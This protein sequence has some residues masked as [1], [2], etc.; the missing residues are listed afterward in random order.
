MDKTG[1]SNSNDFDQ[2]KMLMDYLSAMQ[3]SSNGGGGGGGGMQGNNGGMPGNNASIQDMMMA[4]QYL[5][6]M[7]NMGMGSGMPDFSNAGAGGSGPGGFGGN[8][9]M[10]PAAWGMNQYPPYLQFLNSHFHK[11]FMKQ[12]NNVH[13]SQMEAVKKETVVTR[14]STSG[15]SN[16]EAKRYECEY[17]HKTF[18]SRYYMSTHVATHCPAA[19]A[20]VTEPLKRITSPEQ[21]RLL[22][23]C[24]QQQKDQG[25]PDNGHMGKFTCMKCGRW[26]FQEQDY[27]QHMMSHAGERPYHCNRCGKRYRYVGN[28]ESHKCLARINQGRSNLFFFDFKILSSISRWRFFFSGVCL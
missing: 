28:L 18:A 23:K 24:Q 7:S 9:G 13:K 4:K 22:E 20:S 19:P 1:D 3:P 10:N 25:M 14:P 6:Q 11:E 12:M 26:F 17:C 8:M 16:S 21:L 15:S 2:Q 5:E 27:K